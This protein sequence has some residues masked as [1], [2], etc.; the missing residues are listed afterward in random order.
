M[1]DADSNELRRIASAVEEIAQTL[2]ELTDAIKGRLTPEEMERAGDYARFR[3]GDYSG[4][5][6]P[7][8]GDEY[9]PLLDGPKP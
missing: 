6:K 3:A 1:N 5:A 7:D 9:D 2:G 4:L 8:A